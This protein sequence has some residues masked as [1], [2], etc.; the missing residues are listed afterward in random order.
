MLHD[1]LGGERWPQ[2]LTAALIKGHPRCIGRPLQL[3]AMALRFL[4]R[5][6][7]TP[8]SIMHALRPLPSLP[9][10]PRPPATPSQP[11]PRPL[12]RP[13]P[14]GPQEQVGLACRHEQCD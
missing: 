14:R 12:G 5:P 10:P 1:A 6:N 13:R 8:P 3:A 9:F 7:P 2:P 4:Y 11:T